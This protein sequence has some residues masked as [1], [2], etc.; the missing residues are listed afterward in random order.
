[1]SHTDERGAPVSAQSKTARKM[2]G[3][4]GVRQILLIRHGATRLNNDDT[5]VDRIRG[6]K[7]IPLSDDGRKE[8]KRLGPIVAKHDPDVLYASDLHRARET[9]A[10]ICEHTS[11]KCEK[12]T[13]DFRPWDV[14]EFA[15]QKSAEAA[16]KL[17]KYAEDKPDTPVPG[18]ESFNS[19]RDRFF[20]GLR[21]ALE[22]HDG[23]VGIV[24]HHR[25]E[26]LLKAWVK[27]GHRPD[28]KVD[29]GE[30]RK[31]GEPTGHCEII[32]IPVKRLNGHG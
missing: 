30:F 4:D 1:M 28:G 26:R 29:E 21:K 17:C 7:D 19:F 13:K 27:G 18:G 6:W 8:A 25:A 31:K 10:I 9:A 12:P 15:G 32:N 2:S 16:P 24:S 20:G 23:L 3:K 11:V 22:K 14:G 5:S